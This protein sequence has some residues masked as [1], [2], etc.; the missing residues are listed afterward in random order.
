[1][2]QTQSKEA[3]E[4]IKPKINTSHKNILKAVKNVKKPFCQKWLLEK[5]RLTKN[6]YLEINSITPRVNELVG[7]GYLENKGRMKSPYSDIAVFHYLI[8]QKGL[9]LIPK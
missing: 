9:D 7:L 6:R 2:V 8:T 1:M 3:Y 5:L 4:N